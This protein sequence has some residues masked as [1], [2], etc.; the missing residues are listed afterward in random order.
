MDKQKTEFIS[1]ASHQ[2]RAPI[3]SLK[4]YPSMILEGSYGPI[5]EKVS[6]V[7]RRIYQSSQSL[8]VIIDDFLNLSRIERGKI[9]FSFEIGDMRNVIKEAFD[10]T[11]PTAKEKGLALHL[12]LPDEKCEINMDSDKIKQMCINIIN[13]SI[14]YTPKG[15]VSVTLIKKGRKAIL[16]VSDTGIGIPK[17]E[18]PNLFKKFHRLSNANGANIKGTGLGLY[19]AKE[20]VKAHKGKIWCDS[21]GEGKGSSFFVELKCI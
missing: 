12:E 3:A 7:V 1:I 9:E 2:L 8:A 17:K 14:K 5:P 21:E 16:R 15:S 13:N 18:M 6:D 19:L 4:G 20:I 10:T 11:R